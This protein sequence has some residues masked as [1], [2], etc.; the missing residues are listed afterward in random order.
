MENNN[1]TNKE[2]I[3]E[4]EVKS[5]NNVK[6]IEKYLES[7]SEKE[8]KAY[9][10]AKS[11]LGMSFQLEKSNGYLNYLRVREPT[12]RSDPLKPLP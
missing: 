12:F 3:I 9:E 5:E 1:I 11:H 6:N 4:N 7:L 8:K 2:D 10:I